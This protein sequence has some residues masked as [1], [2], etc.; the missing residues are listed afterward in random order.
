MGARVLEEELP[1]G[2]AAAAFNEDGTLAEPELAERFTDVVENL[3]REI[4]SP[5]EQTTAA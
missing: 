3:V 2:M 4:D 1:L 5:L